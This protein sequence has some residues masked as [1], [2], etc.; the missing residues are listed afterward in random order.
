MSVSGKSSWVMHPSLEGGNVL[1]TSMFPAATQHL[2]TRVDGRKE[3]SERH[4]TG[5]QEHVLH[6]SE[7]KKWQTTA[8]FALK[9]HLAPMSSPGAFDGPLV[10]GPSRAG[11]GQTLG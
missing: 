8:M 1:F 4:K 3:A 5:F 2:V 9:P 11:W 10:L 7:C 6:G